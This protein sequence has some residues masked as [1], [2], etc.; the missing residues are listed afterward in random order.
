MTLDQVSPSILLYRRTS[1]AYPD[2]AA[3][4]ESFAA[5]FVALDR[6][7]TSEM[8]LLLDVRAAQ[9]RNDDAFEAAHAPVRVRMLTAFDAVAMVVG[10]VVGKLQVTRFLRELG[11][12]GKVFTDLAEA[13]AWLV[14][15][16]AGGASSPG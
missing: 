8:G 5:L 2:E 13:E 10:T 15:V 12:Q 9:G 1:E 14:Q 4:R 16:L 11:V 3:L 7:A 6:L